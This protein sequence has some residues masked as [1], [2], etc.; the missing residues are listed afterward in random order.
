MNKRF[1]YIYI[2]SKFGEDIIKKTKFFKK[3][4]YKNEFKFLNISSKSSLNINS[5]ALKILFYI[6][7]IKLIPFCDTYRHITINKNPFTWIKFTF[8][9]ILLT[10]FRII[11]FK[12]FFLNLLLNLHN[13]IL[14]KRYKFK[15]IIPKD[16]NRIIIFTGLYSHKTYNLIKIAKLK[17]IKI[18]L[19][20]DNWDNISSKMPIIEHPDKIVF[21][22]NEMKQV[23]NNANYLLPNNKTKVHVIGSYRYSMIID[24]L[25]MRK[26]VSKIDKKRFFSKIIKN[27]SSNKTALCISFFDSIRERN[28]SK[29]LNQL[30]NIIENK[31]KNKIFI[32]Y[33]EHPLKK[34]KKINLG[35]Y[36]NIFYDPAFH[37]KNK[38]I[39]EFIFSKTIFFSDAV[40]SQVSTVLL[41]IDL[42]NKRKIILDYG[43]PKKLFARMKTS[44]FLKYYFKKNRNSICSHESELEDKFTQFVEKILKKKPYYS[45]DNNYIFKNINFNDYLKKFRLTLKN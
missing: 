3:L 37:K 42:F 21:W 11:V 38:E 32:I 24:E 43:S 12:K 25:S 8:G 17:G 26:K 20:V 16:A 35:P 28:P 45:Q 15:N 39:N 29:I 36:K 4:N 27:Y 6:G 7:S 33:R 23:W 40:I 41:E 30:D 5:I 10:L 19:V 13:N 1:N 2:Q 14:I 31:F 44:Q 34:E 18:I 22:G 9:I